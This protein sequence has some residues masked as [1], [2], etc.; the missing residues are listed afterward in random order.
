VEKLWNS[1]E[2]PATLR[3]SMELLSSFKKGSKQF[4]RIP[5][6]SLTAEFPKKSCTSVK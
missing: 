4:Q 2:F 1:P 6:N 5:W 3:K